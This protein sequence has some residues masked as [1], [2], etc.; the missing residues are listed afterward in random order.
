M[1]QQP[2]LATLA[3]HRADGT[4][5]LAPVWYEWDGEAMCISVPLDDVKDRNI[6]RDPR[7]SVSLGEEAA[8]P[9]RGLELVGAAE[10]LPDPGGA[11]FL[12]ITR[13]YLGPGVAEEWFAQF[14]GWDWIL[15][16]IV[17]SRVRAWDH[18]DEPILRQA[19][20]IFPSDDVRAEAASSGVS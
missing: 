7:V 2:W 20:P 16:R 11:H 9:G 3:T 8:Y 13:R 14:E 19:R 12:R 5:L 10:R 15:L 4:I 6:Q 1:L 18:V 17:P